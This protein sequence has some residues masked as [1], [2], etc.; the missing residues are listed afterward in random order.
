MKSLKG[1]KGIYFL[2]RWENSF[3][4]NLIILFIGQYNL[5]VEARDGLGSGPFTDIAD[6]I[7]NIQSINNYRPVF[8]MPAL[9]NASVELL[10]VN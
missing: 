5:K 3:F 1:L 7:I 8:I 10:E 9:Y 4:F 2:L 6:I